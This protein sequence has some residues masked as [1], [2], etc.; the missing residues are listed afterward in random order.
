[1]FGKKEYLDYGDVLIRPRTSS[2][3]SRKD[4]IVHRKFRGIKSE[5]EFTASPIIVANLDTT[6]TF[7]VAK[8][9]GRLGITTALHKFYTP[10]Q[11]REA[12]T[13]FDAWVTIGMRDL[14]WEAKVNAA[15]TTRICIDV[16]NGYMTGFLDFIVRVR[17]RFPKHYIMAGNICTPDIMHL[18]AEA[19]VDAVKVG[20]GQGALCR[21]RVTAGIGVPQFTAVYDCAKR[22]KWFGLHV[23]ADGG[24]S[25]YAD[26][27][28]ALVAG[29]DFVMAGSMF[30][31][32]DETADEFYN[33]ERNFKVAYGMSS[34][35]AM[36]KHYGGKEAHRASE[37]RTVLVPYKGS[38]VDTANEIL[39][40]I[41]STMT[42]T[43]SGRVEEL[44]KA[45][46]IRVN[47]TINA[48]FI[49]QTIA[50]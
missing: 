40:S 45:K 33:G 43:D 17:N 42:Y 19:G 1:M 49:K 14:D 10:E 15:G 8:T 26:F 25:E 16:A 50:H 22:A 21:T 12:G 9:L 2:Y 20:I 6:G 44:K 27:S 34:A 5:N 3:D 36:D 48:T 46:W 4:V 38:I 18:Y 24:I 13:R 29:A 35:T 31:G 23:C 47:S 32:H 37:G 41:R 11:L 30:T 7:E 39:G 28:K